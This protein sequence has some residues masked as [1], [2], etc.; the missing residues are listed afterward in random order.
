MKHKLLLARIS[1]MGLVMKVNLVGVRANYVAKIQWGSR[2]HKFWIES[3]KAEARG[4]G[5]A[6]RSD[7]EHH[8]GQMALQGKN[9]VWGSREPGE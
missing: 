8:F 4:S 6:D 7:D 3:V 2:T 1:F 9:R 5:Y